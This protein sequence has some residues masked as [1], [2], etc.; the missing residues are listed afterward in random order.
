MYSD[1]SRIISVNKGLRNSRCRW[2]YIQKLYVHIYKW[3]KEF[4]F[5]FSLLSSSR[6]VLLIFICKTISER[7][8]TFFFN[9]HHPGFP[10]PA[11]IQS[12]SLSRFIILGNGWE[13][14][15]QK[16]IFP[17]ALNPRSSELPLNFIFM[18]ELRCLWLAWINSGCS[19]TSGETN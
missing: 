11:G 7:G 1:Y 9:T 6:F 8:F 16:Y 2:G 10:P 3:L 14:P 15:D 17:S 5:S 13:V 19:I 18:P 4:F 12:Q